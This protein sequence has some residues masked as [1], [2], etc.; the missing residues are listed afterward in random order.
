MIQ[1]MNNI[2]KRSQKEIHPSTGSPAR[3][4]FIAHWVG[5]LTLFLLGWKVNAE[6]PKFNKLIILGVP[7]TSGMDLVLLLA[8]AY[9][10]RIKVNWLGKNTLFIPVFG[11]VLKFF[12]GIPVIRDKKLDNVDN[13]VKKIKTMENL[14]L[15]IAP[16]GTRSYTEYWKSGFYHIASKAGI[17]VVMGYL[18]YAKKESGLGPTLIPGN[19]VHND[20]DIIRNFYDPITACYPENKGIIR[21]REELKED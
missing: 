9:S 17:P 12:G 19:N 11:D 18:D 4:G 14:S 20:M 8:T 13:L 3:C 15:V 21:L 7:H 6:V 5:R 10:L 2:S 1:P 16:E